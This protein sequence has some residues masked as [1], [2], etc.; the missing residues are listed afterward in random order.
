M[1]R[2]RGQKPTTVIAIDWPQGRYGR[3]NV[4]KVRAGNKEGLI[5]DR[6]A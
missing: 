5:A 4:K 6:T 2:V 3:K 1:T